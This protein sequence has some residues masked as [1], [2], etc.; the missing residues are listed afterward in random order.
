MLIAKHDT[1]SNVGRSL[2]R[3]A[4][5]AVDSQSVRVVLQR[6]ASFPGGFR[7]ITGFPTP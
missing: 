7:I 6:D 3:G 5:S 4:P 2:S 1:G